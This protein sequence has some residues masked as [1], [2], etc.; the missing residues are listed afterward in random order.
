MDRAVSDSSAD[1]SAGITAARLWRVM[2]RFFLQAAE[3]IEPR[4]A[5]IATT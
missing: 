5:S 4:N 1:A 2:R 3:V